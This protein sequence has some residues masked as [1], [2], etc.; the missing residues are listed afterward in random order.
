MSRP[1]CRRIPLLAIAATVTV[2]LAAAAG[3]TAASA[4][5]ATMI[6]RTS[7]INE[8]SMASGI[9]A[10]ATG[11]AAS[12]R[13]AAG[14]R[15]L[16][17][18][19]RTGTTRASTVPAGTARAGI[20]RAARIRPPVARGTLRIRGDLRD[21]GIVHASGL[22]W[23]PGRL[24]P[25]QRL[26]SFEV[27]Y[28]WRSC[29]RRT[30]RCRRA[31]DRTATPFAA[32]RYV[33]GHADTGRSLRL[34]ETAAEVVQTS[35]RGFSFRIIRS[36]ASGTTSRTVRAFGRGRRPF[37]AFVNGLPE[38]RTGSA[39]EYFEVSAPHYNA[40]DGTAG[41][42][43]RIDHGRWRP[44]PG[45]RVFFTGKLAVGPHRVTVRTADRA[46]AT[47][48]GFGWRIVSRAPPRPCRRPAGRACWYPPH[49][50]RS[51]HPMRWDWQIGLAAPRQRTGARAVDIY[52]I[53]GF[54]T[55][56]REVSAM[57]A[58]WRARTLAHP[59]AVCY[60]DLAWED[61]RPDG[62]PSPHGR[63]FPAA[64]LGKV[65][66]GFPQERW[67]DFR[68]LSELKPMLKE[69]IGR[70]ARKGFDAV[71][72]DDIDSFDPP[73]TTGFHLT[74][75]D[76]QNF[77]AYAFNLVHRDGMTALWKNTPGLAWWGARYAD[78]AVVEECYIYHECFAAWQRGTRQD[79]IVC[80]K[81]TGPTPCGW[82]VFTTDVTA[83]QP[84]GKWVGEA[85][86]QQDKFVCSP[87]RHCQRKRAF[88]TYCRQV[89]S[90]ARGFAAVKFSADLDGRLFYPCPKGT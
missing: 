1:R 75:G 73:S 18:T 35:G 61:Y 60:L 30:G 70:C 43:Y 36:R 53:D 33:A 38:R 19:G 45:N 52:D 5:G 6:S 59:K 9:A 21:G 48:R 63:Y 17:G 46:G 79:G 50:D 31:A 22:R 51:G 57:H 10:E 68:Q 90:P 78:G 20:A 58:S 83:R 29:A 71:E 8:A 76:A 65:Y 23:R 67:V 77:L 42:R 84:T 64:A 11:S 2:T 16:S 47:L 74:P 24:R 82:D 40:A 87:G 3:P 49:L 89:Y 15:A 28:R 56:R 66:F 34:T 54:L 27:L 14:G 86:Y 7:I 26:L 41:Q 62:S 81:L 80:S 32:R 39:E 13:A 4:A 69:R 25:G 72:L 44:L 85:E 12:G 55:T 37:S 88:R